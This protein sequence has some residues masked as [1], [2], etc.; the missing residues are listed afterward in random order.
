M[1]VYSNLLLMSSRT[2]YLKWVRNAYKCYFL[3]AV[4]NIKIRLSVGHLLLQVKHG[5]SYW[6]NRFLTKKAGSISWIVCT[7]AWNGLQSLP[8]IFVKLGDFHRNVFILDKGLIWQFSFWIHYSATPC[9]SATIGSILGSEFR[10]WI[11]GGN[12]LLMALS[13]FC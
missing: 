2:T 3:V 12:W 10:I 6:A 11:S 7:Q 13:N 8:V 1:F 4:V 5:V 9:S